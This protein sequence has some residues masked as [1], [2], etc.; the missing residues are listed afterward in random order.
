MKNNKFTVSPLF[1]IPLYQ[2]NLGYLPHDIY[3]KLMDLEFERT[4]ANINFYSVNKYILNE[5]E[6]KILK[7][8]IMEHVN[9]FIYEF[10]DVKENMKFDIE[11]SWVNKYLP[12]DYSPEHYHGNSLISGVLYLDVDENTGPITFYKDKTH[13]NLWTET[14]RVDF[15]YQDKS[16]NVGNNF[17]N[18][19]AV[20]FR[21][22][23]GDLVLFP[24]LLNHEAAVNQSEKV[25][26]SLAFNCFPRGTAGGP[27][28]SITI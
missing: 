10:L 22:K 12:D 2:S 21:P 4:P 9:F 6:L 16:D 27:I 11:N 17:Y 7:N 19:Q 3:Q 25:R 23:K 26:Y 8:K 13:Y 18:A 28:N 1:A 20:Q 24:S 14:I 5:P 15:K